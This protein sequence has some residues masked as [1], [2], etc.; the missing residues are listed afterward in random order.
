MS[1]APRHIIA[2]L[3]AFQFHSDLSGRL[4]SLSE[5]DQHLFLEW[6]DLRQLTLALPKVSR[7]T[8]PAWA[9]SP[10]CAKESRYELRFQRLRRD[11]FEI[12]QA[13]DEA[14]LEFVMLKGLS[15]A[16]SLS[17]DAKM[18]S[19]GDIDLWLR[20]SD[21]YKAQ[22]VLSSLGYVPLLQ[23]KS[24][25]LAPMG[26]PSSWKWR[27]DLFDPEMPI[28]VELHYELWSEEAEYFAVPEVEHFWDRKELRDF[29]GRQINVLCTEDLLGFAALHLLLHLL[30]GD[31]PLQRAWEIAR[32]L[33]LRSSDESFW[34][35]WHALHSANLRRLEALIFYLVSC[36]F[37]NQL[38]K[39]LNTE[40]QQLPLTMKHWLESYYQAPLEREW[41]PNKSETWLHLALIDNP[42]NRARVFFRRLVPT[43]LP[44]FTD[45]A[46]A[47]QTPMAKLLR[48][49]RQLH[50]IRARLVHHVVTFIPTLFDGLRWFLLR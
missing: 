11:L 19:Q 50:F 29:D 46:E 40:F 25:H 36:W 27:G 5:P 9:V 8:L 4:S 15:H 47:R 18:R 6:C 39:G 48:P 34:K 41:T 42:W 2:A 1:K 43:S 23:S 22:G 37:Q 14:G 26:R 32:F 28:S 49:L 21:V 24:R 31:L 3:E 38:H 17:P 10:I 30:H 45:S 7:E 16:P 33:D 12:V 13:F 44:H 35:S 20:G